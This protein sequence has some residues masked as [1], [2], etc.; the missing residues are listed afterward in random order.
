MAA[1]APGDPITAAMFPQLETVENGN[2]FSPTNTSFQTGTGGDVCSTT[3][4]SPTSGN[5]SY[6]LA[7]IVSAPASNR[8][9]LAVQIHEGSDGTG[10]VVHSAS[11][12]RCIRQAG[13]TDI[14]GFGI[15]IGV[16]ALTPEVTHYAVVHHQVSGGT[17]NIFHRILTVKPST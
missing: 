7:A 13:H 1:A 14:V 2:N 5:V 10:T 16:E 15:T 4:V 11:V 3:F 17:G 6:S 8:I 9:E 12:N